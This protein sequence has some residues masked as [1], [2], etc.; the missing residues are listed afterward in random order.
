MTNP[1]PPETWPKILIVEDNPIDVH[2]VKL[3]LKYAGYPLTPVVVND[4]IPALAL[5]KRQPPFEEET[6]PDLVILDLNLK[7][8]DGPQVVEEIRTSLD[9]A[10]LVVAILSS[11]PVDMMKAQ[12][13]KANCFFRKD[14]D[15][16]SALNVGAQL[17]QCYA[18][19]RKR[20]ERAS[21][22]A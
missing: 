19:H 12:A 18:I 20:E 5:L 11:S 10:G 3:A 1:A 16:K 2:M 7:K 9:L 22:S 21:A 4:G 13:P 8:V 14:G 17:L 15:L 6:T